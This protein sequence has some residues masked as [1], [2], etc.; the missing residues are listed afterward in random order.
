MAKLLLTRPYEDSLSLASKLE[1][2]NVKT[3]IS[4]VLTL[5]YFQDIVFPHNYFTAIVT[6]RH[7]IR[8]LALNNLER[9]IP[10]IAVGDATAEMAEKLGFYRV[11]RGENSA[12]SLISFIL[13]KVPTSQPL[14]YAHGKTIKY[15]LHDILEEEGY[16]IQNLVVYDAVAR[17][18][19]A[20]EVIT[21]LQSRE[22]THVAFFSE[23]SVKI[24][25]QQL[26][27][28]KIE[29]VAQHLET[30]AFSQDIAQQLFGSRWKAVHVLEYPSLNSFL[31]FCGSTL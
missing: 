5:Q 21:A 31:Q 27:H 13:E 15:Y 23:R 19:M 2:L 1:A 25:L 3:L 24:F 4:P 9:S 18:E 20:P 8:A 26:Q 11:S 30:I 28:H 7:G 16:S 10:I 22:I 29:D 17:T 14:I 6:S 12:K